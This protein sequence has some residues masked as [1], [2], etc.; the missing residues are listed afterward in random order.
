MFTAHVTDPG[1]EDRPYATSRYGVGVML[2]SQEIREALLSEHFVRQ[3]ADRESAVVAKGSSGPEIAEAAVQS[4]MILTSDPT[5]SD[6]D[7]Q[8]A[9]PST[10]WATAEAACE[11][12][13]SSRCPYRSIVNELETLGTQYGTAV[14]PWVTKGIAGFTDFFKVLTKN[15]G[16]A[17]ALGGVITAVLILAIGVYLYRA[18]LS[19]SGAIRTVVSGYTRRILGQTAERV[20]L[21]RTTAILTTETGA[22][23]KLVAADEKLATISCEAGLSGG[24]GGLGGTGGGL[25]NKALK[26]ATIVGVGYTVASMAQNGAPNA[27]TDK[28]TRKQMVQTVLGEMGKGA[29][30]GAGVGSF[31]GPEGTAIGAGVGAAAGGIYAERHQIGHAASSL[32]DDVFNHGSSQ[33]TLPRT[34]AHLVAD[35]YIDGKEV[36][37]AV[38]KNVKSTAVRR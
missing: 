6:L 20:A 4:G 19:S 37:K 29:A 12:A 27:L 33:P 7:P 22:T 38:S 36:T 5:T 24:P 8:P 34:R 14:L 11:P 16:L 9:E 28:E 17:L 21:E 31:A 3:R 26:A 1:Y 15:K 25:A 23:Y 32:W 35:V 2:R 13:S 10:I 18:L 30:L